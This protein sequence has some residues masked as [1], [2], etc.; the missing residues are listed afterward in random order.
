M[1]KHDPFK[2]R[3]T[4]ET[5]LG[6]VDYFDL[7]V[8]TE[9]GIG[10]L[11]RLPYSIRILLEAVLRNQDGF[12]VTEAHVDAIA[13]YQATDVG[14]VE[15]PFNPGRVVLQDFTGVPAVVD[16]A[17]LRSAMHRLGGDTQKVNPLVQCDLVIDHSVQVDRFGSDDALDL[18][19]EIEFHRNKE[20]YEFLKR[21]Q[22]SF[23]NFRVVPPATGI[24]HQVN[25]SISL[26]GRSLRTMGMGG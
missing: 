14:E 5:P 9:K 20:R 19:A 17:A 11:D 1:A 4:L 22:Q 15:I 21:G 8:L 26:K 12:A 16:L 24:V 2:A 7:N 18:N 25:L 6:A 10:H 23:E 3:K 13:N